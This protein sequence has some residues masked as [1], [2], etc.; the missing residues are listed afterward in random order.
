MS[1]INGKYF[2]AGDL[3]CAYHQVLLSP[4]TQKLTSFVIKG[5]QYTY[6]VGFYCFCGLPHWFSRTMADNFESHIKK[7]KLQLTFDDSLL[8]SRTKAEILTNIDEYHQLLRNRSLKVAPDKSHFF[9]IKV[10][11][12]GPVIPER[13]IQPVTNRLNDL[14]FPESKRGVMKVPECLGF[15]NCYIK[16][17]HVDSQPFFEL[18]KNTTPSK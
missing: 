16:N 3:S 11:F 4:E 12:L 14:L 8:Q 9:L 18:I 17:L 10:K 1:R 6:Q 15:H 2:T 5:K 7:K 13:R